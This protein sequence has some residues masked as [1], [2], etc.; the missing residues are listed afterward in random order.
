MPS[1]ITSS[2]FDALSFGARACDV[3]TG[4]L[5]LGE[6][7]QAFLAWFLGPDGEIS[8]A[9]FNAKIQ[10]FSPVGGYI[11]YAGQT[12]PDGWLWCNG[13]A[14]NRTTYAALF[15]AIGTIYGIGDGST[16]FNVPNFGDRVPRGTNTFASVGQTGGA[17]S[18]TLTTANL[19]AHSH[20]FDLEA[21]GSPNQGFEY[22]TREAGRTNPE[23]PGGGTTEDTGS[24]TPF[25]IV[26]SHVK[27]LFI[28]RF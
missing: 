22:A 18:V 15:A 26:P 25:D 2:D 20:T 5:R 6:K 9:A 11:M 21:D 27:S 8:D 14:V 24:S 1:P 23:L 13:Q 3:L 19:A 12:V 7:V 10:K 4:L 16:T 28:I 17:D